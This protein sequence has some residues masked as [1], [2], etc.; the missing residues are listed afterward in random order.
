MQARLLLSLVAFGLLAL[1]VSPL[2]PVSAFAQAEAPAPMPRLRRADDPAPQPQ[3]QPSALPAPSD[4]PAPSAAQAPSGAVSALVPETPTIPVPATPATEAITAVTAAPQP[5]RL[6]AKVTDSGPVIGDGVVWRIF[7]TKPDAA[8]ELPMV[9]KAESAV[10]NLSLPP[11]DYVVHVAFGQAQAS[12]T[13][14]VGKGGG[15]KT[16]VLDAGG[17][18]L[19]A[20]IYGDVAIPATLMR[21][22][23]YNGNEEDERNIVMEGVAPNQIL[24]LNAGTY[25]VVS[26]FGSVNAVIRAN[27]RVEPGQLTEATLF[28]KAAQIALKLVSEPEG[29]A[30]ADIEWTIKTAAGETVFT[31]L[32]AFPSTVLAEGDYLVLAKRGTTVYNR[33]FQVQAGAA[34][35]IEVLTTVY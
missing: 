15:N 20:S 27:L 19:N 31:D 32:G 28:H 22:D 3:P 9:T 34:R 6:D 7:D 11:G 35:E 33:E 30:I 25:H 17:L 10:A 2:A 1:P 23:I 12:D 5:V 29:E 14:A 26:R 13:L 4:S 24:T 21:F 8:G 18:R 16:L